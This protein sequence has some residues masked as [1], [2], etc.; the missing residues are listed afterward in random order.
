LLLGRAHLARC[1]AVLEGVLRVLVLD[2]E[3]RTVV[4]HS[5]AVL[6]FAI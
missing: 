5:H 1:L 2:L 3:A 6:F 4:N